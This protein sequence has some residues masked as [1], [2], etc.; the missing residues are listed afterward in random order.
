M[1]QPLKKKFFLVFIFSQFVAINKRDFYENKAM[2][3]ITGSWA[4]RNDIVFVYIVLKGLERI[5][6]LWFHLDLQAPCATP[7]RTEQV[8]SEGPDKRVAVP[9]S[10]PQ[11]QSG[12]IWPKISLCFLFAVKKH[13]NAICRHL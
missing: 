2:P 9:G 10:R 13:R 8:V 11:S 7:V 12:P 5:G 6:H 4:V 1:P 3:K